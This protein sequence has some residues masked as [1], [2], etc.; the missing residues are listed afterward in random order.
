MY[1]NNTQV[2]CYYEKSTDVASVSRSAFS[3]VLLIS[4]IYC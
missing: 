3:Q 2:V 4:N 1:I